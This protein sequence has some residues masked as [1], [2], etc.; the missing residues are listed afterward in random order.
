MPLKSPV[1]QVM[2]DTKGDEVPAATEAE[3][4]ATPEAPVND[5][6]QPTT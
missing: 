4:P 2:V 1:P 6:S 5:E 3:A